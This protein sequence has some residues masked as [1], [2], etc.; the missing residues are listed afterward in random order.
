VC[1]SSDPCENDSTCVDNY[2]V[3][4]PAAAPYTCVCKQGFTGVNCT[5]GTELACV[6]CVIAVLAC[7]CQSCACVCVCLRVVCQ[8][9]RGACCAYFV[10]VFFA[11]AW[12]PPS[13][14][15]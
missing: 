9:C 1:A 8:S 12:Y 15:R 4:Q 7:V 6:L 2:E 10:L 5:D 3:D 11:V 13:T 14:T